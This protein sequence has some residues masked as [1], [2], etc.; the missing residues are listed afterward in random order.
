MLR[1]RVRAAR[2][3]G[4][5]VAARRRAAGAGRGGR[6]AA[7]SAGHRAGCG[8]G[9]TADAGRCWGRASPAAS[10]CSVSRLSCSGCDRHS[11]SSH[12]LP[13]WHLHH[14]M[15]SSWLEAEIC[16]FLDWL[17]QFVYL[18]G[19]KPGDP[20]PGIPAMPPGWKPGDPIPLPGGANEKAGPAAQ[21]AA[22]QPAAAAVPVQEA[23][24]LQ[25]PPPPRPVLR[26]PVFDADFLMLGGDNEEVEEDFSSE[27]DSDE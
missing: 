9:D 17:T 15:E 21:P 27:E 7:R 8:N 22:A 19:W 26:M 1:S 5:R 14:C 20:L 24:S 18:A 11:L 16:Y 2:G 4:A 23:G 25:K 6:A 3:A 13:V 10:S 12:D